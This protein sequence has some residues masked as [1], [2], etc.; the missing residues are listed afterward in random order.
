MFMY[1]SKD[2]TTCVSVSDPH[3]T[4][5]TTNAVYSVLCT[6]STATRT[7]LALPSTRPD[8]AGSLHHLVNKNIAV[9][10]NKQHL[11]KAVWKKRCSF[12]KKL[13]TDRIDKFFR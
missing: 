4:E 2:V 12:I 7:G 11:P 1:M 5:L 8:A 10:I 9:L 13:N 6:G 3:A